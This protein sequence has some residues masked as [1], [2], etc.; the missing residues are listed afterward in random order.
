MGNF[1]SLNDLSNNIMLTRGH[2]CT[3]Q[4]IDVGSYD[5][6]PE[7]GGEIVFG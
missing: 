1:E 5:K 3:G 2:S 4:S 7:Q 6:V